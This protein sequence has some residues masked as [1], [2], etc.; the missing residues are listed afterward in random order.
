MNAT[1]VYI[2][3]SG[4]MIQSMIAHVVLMETVLTNRDHIGI[5]LHGTKDKATLYW[6]VVIDFIIG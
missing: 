6:L 5:Y 1:R 3:E 4:Q 2:L